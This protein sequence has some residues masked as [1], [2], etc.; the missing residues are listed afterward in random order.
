M[1]IVTLQSIKKDFGIKEI[2]QDATFS[3][4][5]DDKVGL[6]GINGS[7]KSTLL[8]MIAGIESLDSG[9]RL[10]K[11]GATIVYLPQQP[12]LTSDNTVLDQIFADSSEQMTLVR[13]Y[14]ALSHQMAQAHGTNLDSLMTRLAR[15]TEQME[16]AGAWELE[17]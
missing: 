2:L 8:K 17:N 13:E 16:T 15:I 9:Q 1:S 5:A 14:E 12:D 7:G 6:I 11:P 3:I 10:T 4:D